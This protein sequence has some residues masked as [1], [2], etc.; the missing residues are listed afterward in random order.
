MNRSQMIRDLTKE[1]VEN[2]LG[3]TKLLHDEALVE[4]T[5]AALRV[6]RDDDPG[7]AG[8]PAYVVL[9]PN[10]DPISA[11]VTEPTLAD[12]L[13]AREITATI[14]ANRET[15]L[16]DHADLMKLARNHTDGGHAPELQYRPGRGLADRLPDLDGLR[17]DEEQAIRDAAAEEQEARMKIA[18]I[19][20]HAKRRQDEERKRQSSRANREGL[21]AQQR[22]QRLIQSTSDLPRRS[23]EK[24]GY[25]GPEF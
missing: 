3:E 5:L 19:I 18:A 13:T 24:R 10:D 2:V 22:A 11:A 8:H 6:R 16:A 20:R 12:G 17:D 7:E 14:T 1:Y 21:T 23:G 25:D 15:M 9:G 4:P